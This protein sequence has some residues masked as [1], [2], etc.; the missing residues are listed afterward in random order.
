[1][2]RK[3]ELLRALLLAACSPDEYFI[4]ERLGTCWVLRTFRFHIVRRLLFQF[5]ASSDFRKKFRDSGRF[6]GL[7]SA[8]PL[9][10]G[11]LDAWG[12]MQLGL[13]RF[14]AGE[15]GA[16]RAENFWFTCEKSLTHFISGS[17][18]AS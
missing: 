17:L 3:I 1:M 15:C 6:G 8:F 13:S 18:R 12:W 14:R 7:R 11:T 10:L 4:T 16:L 5:A 2:V 9:P